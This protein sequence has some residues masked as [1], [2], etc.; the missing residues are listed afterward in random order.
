M[1][2]KV[3]FSQIYNYL[4]LEKIKDALD[5][6]EPTL[7]EVHQALLDFDLKQCGAGFLNDHKD[8]IVQIQKVKNIAATT[9]A[10]QSTPRMILV[11][12]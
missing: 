8:G 9:I 10:Q 4:G 12:G 6:D 5:N 3:N 11:R 2:H 7:D 1:R